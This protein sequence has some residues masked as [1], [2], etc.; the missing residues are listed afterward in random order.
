MHAALARRD[1]AAVAVTA[2]IL[3]SVFAA[4]AVLA[5]QSAGQGVWVCCRS[6]PSTPPA[7]GAPTPVARPRPG[8]Q[9][10]W[11][12]YAMLMA[13]FHALEYLVTAWYH[14]DTV[15]HEG[16]SSRP[17]PPAVRAAL[18]RT[19]PQRSSSTTAP[20]TRPPWSPAGSSSGSSAG[21]PR[22]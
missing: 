14:P 20:S 13:A 16:A 5:V 4:H 12:L 9:P 15:T 22:A 2:L 21:S 18:S 11:C 7:A 10:P 1:R 6:L 19:F 8:S 3:G 17:L